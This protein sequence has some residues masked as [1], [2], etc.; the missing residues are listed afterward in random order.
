VARNRR[1][2]SR[3]FSICAVARWSAARDPATGPVPSSGKSRVAARY[4]SV[5]RVPDRG[6]VGPRPRESALRCQL[7]RRGHRGRGGALL[8]VQSQERL[9]DGVAGLQRGRIGGLVSAL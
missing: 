5:G 9:R 1:I 3:A 7:D 6:D 8:V 4:A 2:D